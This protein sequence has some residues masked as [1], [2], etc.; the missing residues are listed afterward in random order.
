MYFLI[1]HVVFAQILLFCYIR[2]FGL[3]KS[4][5]LLH[6]NTILLHV[7]TILLHVTCNWIS[8]DF[9]TYN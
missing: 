6:L 7:S 9:I 5:D 4:L 2:R 1:Q 8:L 3:H